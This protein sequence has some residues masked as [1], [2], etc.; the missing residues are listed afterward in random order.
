MT[1]GPARGQDCV[2]PFRWAGET[3]YTCAKWT[4]GG[5]N[6]GKF[7]CSTKCVK[8]LIFSKEKKAFYEGLIT[9]TTTSMAREILV[10]AARAVRFCQELETAARQMLPR[11]AS[12]SWSRMTGSSFLTHLLCCLEIRKTLRKEI[13]H[14]VKF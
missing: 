13:I 1:E 7:W 3:H 5:A 2:F 4:F 8:T 11:E 12:L 6:Q 14:L 10:S 9:R